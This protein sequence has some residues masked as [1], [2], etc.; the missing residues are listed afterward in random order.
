MMLPRLPEMSEVAIEEVGFP[1]GRDI[2]VLGKEQLEPTRP[3]PGAADDK[4][5]FYA[6]HAIRI[7]RIEKMSERWG[8]RWLGPLVGL[9]CEYP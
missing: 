8:V 5:M 6:C 1:R 7:E 2:G 4:H 9:A 3:A